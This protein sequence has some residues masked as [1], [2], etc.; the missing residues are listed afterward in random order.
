VSP[1]GAKITL[2]YSGKTDR[3]P[4]VT[5]DSLCAQHSNT[6]IFGLGQA[7]AVD[8]LEVRWPNGKTTRLDKPAI[9]RYY[10]LTPQ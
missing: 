8:F 9:D 6:K 3:L 1:I 4:V 2:R 7:T 10:I 5:G